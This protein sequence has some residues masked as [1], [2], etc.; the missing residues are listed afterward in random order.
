[1]TNDLELSLG[2]ST[3]SFVISMVREDGTLAADELYDVGEACGFT[4]HQI[5]LCLARL[6]QEGQFVQ[7]G[8]GRKANLRTTDL[9]HRTF[10]PELEHFQLGFLQD[11]GRA[12]WDGRWHLV[13]FSIDEE[14]RAARN[15]LRAALLWTGAP[16]AGGL[17]V[18][19]N[20][21]ENRIDAVATD[22]GVADSLV[23]VDTDHLRVGALTDP[24]LVAAHLWP[25][26]DIAKRWQRFTEEAQPLWHQLAAE[27]A[28]DQFERV[29]FLA[30]VVSISAAF[31]ACLR[32]DPLL[33]PELLPQPWPGTEARRVILDTRELFDIGRDKSGLPALQRRYDQILSAVE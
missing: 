19:P 2:L 29:R 20:A 30:G 31:E 14:R 1:M 6:V 27:E 15:T 11:A 23:Y 4:L 16:M 17:Y 33:P 32:H 9:G 25:L 21:W 5:R 10:V 12:P 8:R 18:S 22:L 13:G 24:P 28:A 3:R 7:E 26:D